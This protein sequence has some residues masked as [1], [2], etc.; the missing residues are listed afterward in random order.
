MQIDVRGAV[1]RF[2]KVEALRGIDLVVPAGR[3]V[4]LVGPNGSGKSTLI[5]ALL[6][7]IDCEGVVLLDGEGG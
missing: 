1:K 5:R 2:G 4:A 7:L 6:G 3:R